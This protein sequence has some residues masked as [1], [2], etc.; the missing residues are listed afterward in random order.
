MITNKIEKSERKVDK[1]NESIGHFNRWLRIGDYY[2]HRN[3]KIV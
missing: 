3:F 2:F 1:I